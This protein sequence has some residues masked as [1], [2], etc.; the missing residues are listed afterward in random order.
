MAS[1]VLTARERFA[2]RAMPAMPDPRTIEQN[3]SLR[4]GRIRRRMAWEALIKLVFLW[5]FWI[6]LC[7]W[8]GPGFAA[9][10]VRCGALLVV[11]L[12]GPAFFTAGRTMRKR[13]L[14]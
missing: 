3:V 9:N 2:E 14:R 12:P 6:L 7:H 1:A 10:R 5:I 8:G 11:L 13:A 4:L